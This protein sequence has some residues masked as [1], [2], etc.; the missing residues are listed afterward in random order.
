MAFTLVHT[1]AVAIK[2]VFFQLGFFIKR[3]SF[4]NLIWLVCA[5]FTAQL[6]FMSPQNMFT[7]LISI[8]E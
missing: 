2:H 6:T 8:W 3:K 4:N 7:E 1:E 5:Q